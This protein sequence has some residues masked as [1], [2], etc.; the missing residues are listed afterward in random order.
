MT[1]RCVAFKNVQ[2]TSDRDMGVAVSK[3]KRSS[4]SILKIFSALALM[5]G[6]STP[7]VADLIEY[8]FTG[9][10]G[11]HITKQPTDAYSNASD[12]IRFA[13]AA[14][15][16]RRVRI[17]ILDKEGSVL[18]TKTSHLLGGAD[19]IE[20]AGKEYYGAFLELRAPLQEGEYIFRS[21][22]ISAAGVP[23]RVD[24]YPAIIDR[25][26]PE[27]TALVAETS[28]YNQVTTGSVWKLGIGGSGPYYMHVRDIIDNSPI[29]EATARL[30]R[31]DGSL[32]KETRATFDAPSG[33]ASVRF[34]QGFF[35]SSNLDEKFEVQ[36]SIT[37]MAGNTWSSQRQSVYFDNISNPPT[38]PFAV[39][40]PDEKGS[41]AP[42]LDG[43][44]PYVAGMEVKANPIRLA[45]K[46]PKDNWS[47]YADGGLTL[48]NS[49]GENRVAAI[50]DDHVYVVLSAPFGNTNNNF[51][52]WSNFGQWGGGSVQY[53]LKLSPS[54][55]RTPV[56]RN[57]EYRYSDIGWGAFR[58][59]EVSN[60]K[61]PI[62]IDRVRIIGEAR[63]FD[64]RG[65]HRGSCII[66]AG[67]VSCEHP[68]TYTMQPGTTGYLHE[69]ANLTNI[70]NTLRASTLY[71]EVNWNDQHYPIL[72]HEYD[73]ATKALTV[74]VRQPGRGSYFDRL[75]LHSSWIETDDGTRLNV[76]GGNIEEAQQNY[77]FR[78]DLRSLPE[79]SYNLVA[80]ARERHGP[81][82][83]LPLFNFVSDR[84]PPRLSIIAT[85]DGEVSSL[86]QFEVR[87]SDALDPNPVIT[88][89]RLEGGPASENVQ[90]ATRWV[91]GDLYALEYPVMFPSL[92]EG[93]TYTITVTAQDAQNNTSSASVDFTYSPAIMQ[94][95]G[96]H[97]GNIKI[98]AVPHSFTNREGLYPFHT[99]EV[100]LADGSTVSGVYGLTATL[101]A[102]APS[103]LIVS[104]TT[105]R[106]GE[107]VELEPIN[108]TETQGRVSLAISPAE[109]G[110]PGEHNLIVSTAAPNSPML[111]AAFQAWAPQL[112][113]HRK[114]DQPV[115]ILSEQSITPIV[116]G[117]SMCPVTTSASLAKESDPLLA[118]VCLLEWQSIPRGLKEVAVEGADRPITELRGRYMSG[119]EQK[120]AYNIYLFDSDGRRVLI[121]Q[122]EQVTQVEPIDIAVSFSHNL[123]GGKVMRAVETAQLTMF[124]L[125]SAPECRITTNVSDAR[126]AAANGDELTCLI[127]FTE[128]PEDLRLTQA[129]PPRLRG[130]MRSVGAYNVS[131]KASIFNEEGGKVLMEEK[132]TTFEVVHPPVTTSLSFTVSESSTTE[133]TPTDSHPT[134]WFDKSYAVLTQP[135]FG[136][137]EPS[138]RGF[139]YTPHPGY[140][141]PDTFEYRVIDS[142][143][144]YA[145]AAAQ[146]T[147]TK[148]N[149]PPTVSD[150]SFTAPRNESSSFVLSAED[151]N[152]WDEHT[153]EIVQSPSP[154]GISASV[155]DGELRVR[156]VEHWYGTTTLQYRARDLEG[157]KSE[158]AQITITI[159]LGSDNVKPAISFNDP[160]SCLAPNTISGYQFLIED[161][162]SGV[163]EDS[164][165]IQAQFSDVTLD[166]PLNLRNSNSVDADKAL[167]VGPRRYAVSP[168]IQSGSQLD[169]RLAAAFYEIEQN[170]GRLPF[171]L[172]ITA[173]D[174]A[175][176]ASSQT[177]SFDPSIIDD[178]AA[179]SISMS[180]GNNGTLM[181]HISDLTVVVTDDRSGIHSEEVEA[182]LSFDG[183]SIPLVF[184]QTYSEGPR[185]P[186]ECYA[187]HPLRVE[188]RS[189]QSS[190]LDPDAMNLL[191]RAYV[192]GQELT[193]SVQ[194]SDYAGNQKTEVFSFSFT[195]D[196]HRTETLVIPAVKYQFKDE[197]GVSGVSIEAERVVWSHSDS[198]RFIA[199]ASMS[200]GAPVALNGM[201]LYPGQ[202]LVLEPISLME[203]EKLSLEIRSD[204]TRSG[205]DAEIILIPMDSNARTIEIPVH[206]WVPE[207]RISKSSN[208]PVQ[209]FEQATFIPQQTD[210]RACA[211]T[212]N[213]GRAASSKKLQAPV[214]QLVWDVLPTD[215]FSIQADRPEVTGR[216]PTH[217]EHVLGWSIYFFDD[218]GGR[219]LIGDGE[220]TINVTPAAD[221]L[222]FSVGNGLDG[223][224]RIISEASG[225]LTQ[226]RGPRCSVVT[227]SQELA[228]DM[229]AR[230]MPGCLVEWIEMPEG[231]EQEDWTDAPRFSGV[232]DIHE[233][234]AT[235]N[236]RVSSFSTAGQKVEIMDGEQVI[237]LRDPPSPEIQMDT[238]KLIDG[239]L[240]RAP[241]SGG[242]VG[243]Y[244][245]E[246]INAAVLVEIKEDGQLVESDL[247]PQGY[248][249][250]LVYRGRI[251][252]KEKPLWNVTPV[253]IEA[254]YTSFPAV[255]AQKEI[256]ILAVPDEDLRP[257]IQVTSTEVI[258]TN[259]MT[260]DSWIAHPYQS[261]EYDESKMGKWEIRL[262][263][264]LS[265]NNQSELTEYSPTDSQGRASFD[266]DLMS[267]ESTFM[268]IM[269]QARLV[270]PFP[271][272][273]RVVMGGRPLYVTVLRG[274]AID[275]EIHA[276]K[277]K[278]EAPLSFMGKL[279]LENRLDYKALGDVI[280]EMRTPGSQE[281]SSIESSSSISDRFQ[282]VFDA[283]L[284]ELR[285]R[286]FNKNS[287]A[288]FTTES[289]E[290]HAYN[291]PRIT[292]DGPANA[293]IGS[294]ANLKVVATLDGEDVDEKDLFIEWSEDNGDTWVPGGVDYQLH[295]DSEIRVMTMVRV[296]MSDSPE[297]WDDAFSTRRQRVAFRSVAAPRGSI[298][299]SRV[300]EEGKPV[301]WRGSSRPPYPRMDV[302]IEGR[303]I[304]PDGTIVPESEV[305]Y[306]PTREDALR[307]RNEIAYESWIIGFED[308]GAHSTVSRRVTVWQYE[309]PNWSMN[310]RASATQAPAEVNLR[311]R[312]PVGVGR[313]LEDVQY[314]WILPDGAEM[315][316]IRTPDS[317]VLHIEK[318]GYYPVTVR[319]SD[320]RGN[321]S[322]ITEEIQIDP[323]DPWDVD[324]RMTMSNADSRAPLDIRLS[325]SVRGGHPRDRINLYRY[326]LNGE[327]ISNGLRY[328]SVELDAG[329]HEIGLEITSE[330]GET[331]RSSKTIEVQE[332]TPPVCELEARESRSHWR[333][334][335]HCTDETGRVRRHVW[336][337]NG[338]Q[339]VLSGSRISV[340]SREG[341][342]LEVQLSAIDDGGA[343]SEVVTWHG[344]ITE[345]E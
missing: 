186:N 147:V 208:S 5:V 19:R 288:E 6:L 154:A 129:S 92:T 336:K 257:E 56:L 239:T 53:N 78:W 83:R 223:T 260:V 168:V 79:G 18:S 24:N 211:L 318:P 145:E 59:Y 294:T 172:L 130:V 72:T 258:N 169:I 128:T 165:R 203:G 100:K 42:G 121:H 227:M 264:Y 3:N 76:A 167:E 22:I 193:L 263:N 106:P 279:D 236:W 265:T 77:T 151:K 220:E 109:M 184:H 118:P 192:A 99:E 61:L 41:L 329:T 198:V 69:S 1:A 201:P 334:F 328:S 313:Y 191:S 162:D 119:G 233:G 97:E 60:D 166:V 221:A 123:D 11:S 75:R 170:G 287:E 159:P 161:F 253:R 35:P 327:E 141:G 301:Q 144:M 64:Q 280:W 302:Q 36:M 112:S 306:L 81:E 40:D 37:D 94:V 266:L 68:T 205:G 150:V 337:V 195:P 259:G 63:P 252:A 248:S 312:K 323:Q 28:G 250:R 202:P 87:L 262:L 190:L 342:V 194:V 275:S 57:V 47:T 113:L 326:L 58:R 122:G 214:C 44:V 324:F 199:V 108:F 261:A 289:I 171:K 73:E 189:H 62:T 181:Q 104:G 283:G 344:S 213:E 267:M 238:R 178:T 143:G 243:E 101:R 196:V 311:I 156:P 309:W 107:T 173:S 29:K 245:V 268:R 25:T 33:R 45:Y 183:E 182:V 31:E 9:T 269:P 291:V 65:S 46:I 215:T 95:G 307:D 127:E 158:P 157:A 290:I 71:A 124:Q 251:L 341:G 135:E 204:E 255:N 209:L 303:F 314:E 232:F 308:Q 2:A 66:P 148:F 82:T 339:L 179:P 54:A 163:K 91:S 4:L 340:S 137:V 254:Q 333:F 7:A 43:F 117:Q 224:Y 277:V 131:W 242:L 240:Y 273:E 27:G 10:D 139:V 228:Y 315:A 126:A 237:P 197:K 218:E 338:E 176:N 12:Q 111:L 319:I 229:S 89:V 187:R 270:S 74:F 282:H 93:E 136:V 153:F 149:Y 49:L 345:A 241:I 125:G 14:G 132:T 80:G 48:V 300:I 85:T 17:T 16:D 110:K 225:A 174:Y 304:L 298:L 212:A 210:S 177:Y 317:R 285:A 297:D 271:E 322:E 138:I 52:R 55:H 103:P 116:R 325:P 185:S 86:D 272:Y 244:S 133:T 20:I 175:G 335:A 188:F 120:V 39:F 21:E 284:Y 23:V 8:S 246:A 200:D 234:D 15:L 247:A 90:L 140:I 114:D 316:P 50:D 321:I 67:E 98:P 51:I 286:V 295:R 249:E 13:L 343:E 38:Q 276:R 102:D 299:G 331:V 226:D 292:I 206:A 332:N 146:V 152:L 235:F 293:F 207:V 88:S 70:E 330:F 231:M 164:V 30:W 320:R 155:V 256:E 26:A 84:T 219:H 134:A 160:G 105:V 96:E 216:I 278:G 274:E 115:Q 305:E 217:G 32:H 230:S 281:W 180:V 142:S 222:A 34:E 310:V 296:R